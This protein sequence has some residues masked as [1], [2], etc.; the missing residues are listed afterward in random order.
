M[1]DTQS[2]AHTKWECKYHV[3]W[4]P[5]YR[6]KKLFGELRKEL[7]P[8]LRELAK[9]KGSEIIEGKLLIDHVHI[10]IAIP[11][12]Y[13]VSQ[14][15]GYIKGKSAIYIARNYVGRRKNFTG[16]HFW[17]RGYY[18]STVGLDEGVVRQYIRQQEAEDQRIDQLRLFD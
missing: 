5:K 8:V 15:I 14:V 11:P 3:V 10:L 18:V 9:Q 1:T 17:A 4:I 13:A 6:R 7:G 16:E 12:K 2:L